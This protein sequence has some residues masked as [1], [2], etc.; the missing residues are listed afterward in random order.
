MTQR[1]G[2]TRLTPLIAEAA[3]VTGEDDLARV[4]RT[5]VQ[6]AK[7]ATGAPFVALGLLGEHGVLSEFIYAGMS[8]SEAEAIGHP[9]SGRGVLGTVI[10]ENETILLDSIS[11]HPDSVGFPPNHP[12]METFLGVPVA[13]GA[14]AFGNLYLANKDTPFTE[15]DA[16][17]V[18]AL[19]RIAG[20]AVHKA[21]LEARLRK[22][23]VV[24]DRQRIARDLHDSV[25]QD[26]F[27][28]GLTLQ[29]LQGKVSEDTAEIL[30]T[31]I[32]SLD[33]SVT[34][35]RHYVFELRESTTG[36]PDFDQ[37]VQE[38]V[39]RM[40]SA[41]PSRVELSI[42]ALA[43]APWHE[44]LLLWIAEALSNALRHSNSETIRVKVKSEDDHVVASVVDK[45]IG[46]E[47]SVTKGGMG[48]ANMHTRAQAM[49]GELNIETSPS[50][51]TSVSIRIPIQ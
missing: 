35:L 19:S 45:G 27:A 29:S 48:L 11:E 18:E 26:L 1:P 43:D 9:P 44:E 23:A 14:E 21:R 16:L 3:A 39:S 38:L 7:R 13:V 4:L 2:L 50:T 40:G 49:A 22:V 34:S 32:D 36:L 28:V 15:S 31:A 10:R 20:A 37:R 51:G 8:E 24:E 17:V 12:P 47:R 41:Y 25:I 46:F 5:L 33:E 6:E 42:E 30:A